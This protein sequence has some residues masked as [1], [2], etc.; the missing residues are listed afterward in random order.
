[1]NL[2]KRN[3]LKEWWTKQNT[4]NLIHSFFLCLNVRDAFLNVSIPIYLRRIIHFDLET[5]EWIEKKIFPSDLNNFFNWP[6][7]RCL[8][9][10]IPIA[11]SHTYNNEFRENFIEGISICTKFLKRK[12]D[13]FKNL[14]DWID[15]SRVHVTEK[16]LKKNSRDLLPVGTNAVATKKYIDWIKEK[17][18]LRIKTLYQN[19]REFWNKHKNNLDLWNQ[20]WKFPLDTNGKLSE[21]PA[22]LR[23]SILH[24]KLLGAFAIFPKSGCYLGEW[25]FDFKNEKD[26]NIGLY[27]FIPRFAHE[28]I[29]LWKGNLISNNEL[30]EQEQQQQQEQNKNKLRIDSIDKIK[31]KLQQDSFTE[32]KHDHFRQSFIS[33][34]GKQYFLE[35]VDQNG[36]EIGV[37]QVDE[38]IAHFANEPPLEKENNCLTIL[39]DDKV[40]IISC[41]EINANDEIFLHYH[42][43]DVDKKLQK[44]E[45]NENKKENKKAKTKTEDGVVFSYSNNIGLPFQESR[46]TLNIF[47]P[48]KPIREWIENKGHQQRLAE[49]LRARLYQYYFDDFYWRTYQSPS[50]Y[51]HIYLD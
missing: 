15:T 17:P 3:Q 13:E 9:W 41:K 25:S 23:K 35:V 1:M 19:G 12:Y 49:F 45:Q 29:H 31:Y 14:Q 51:S 50:P 36:N 47:L 27:T 8:E 40:Y 39:L 30:F 6:I 10:N 32:L 20:F 21:I 33:K 2:E 44:E 7:T 38:W 42:V 5:R 37:N 4:E 26:W 24:A 18:E 46:R 48:G 28:N 11:L 16:D 34:L 22:D 43:K